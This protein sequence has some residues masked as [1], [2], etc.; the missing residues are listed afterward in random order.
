[1]NMETNM[2]YLETGAQPGITIVE[3]PP[4]A[5]TL[6][7]LMDR[8]AKALAEAKTA[9]EVLDAR[10]MAS[11]AYDMAKKV[12]RLA[13]VKQAHDEVISALFRA[14]AD[15]LTIEAQAKRRLADEYDRAQERGE[16]AKHGGIRGNQH[17]KVCDENVATAADIGLSRLEI[18]EARE[19]RDAERADPG[20]VRRAVDDAVAA[21]EEPTKAKVR[22]AVKK[23][24]KRGKPKKKAA[25]PFTKETQHERELRVLI[26]LWTVSCDSA[27]AEFQDKLPGMVSLKQRLSELQGELQH[28][29]HSCNCGDAKEGSH[30]HANDHRAGRD[31]HDEIAG[32]VA[33]TGKSAA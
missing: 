28:I 6:A 21:G 5:M 26:S 23:A 18:H 2:Q 16:V 11:V 13:K 17:A 3:Q 24:A 31:A 19:I 8:A 33:L 22:R 25:E 20:V 29:R 9:A 32:G 7:V 27:R 15:A 12:A 4:G 30:D 14:Q 10:D 1:M